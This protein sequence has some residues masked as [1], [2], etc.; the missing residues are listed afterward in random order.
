[1]KSLLDN[2]FLNKNK[3][4]FLIAGPCVIESKKMCLEHAAAL[5]E[6]CQRQGI[7]FIFKSSYD[8]A[9]RT[10]QK[11]FRGPGIKSGLS[12][13]KTVKRE[14]SVPICSDVHQLNEI[15]IAKDILDLIQIPALLCRQT[16]L[17]LAA[18]RTQKPINVKKG[19]FLSPNDM[20]N[21]VEKIINCG[22]KRIIITERGT[23][24]GYNNLVSDMR[25]IP[26]MKKFGFPIVFDATHSV[27]LPGAGKDKSHG[28]RQ[29]VETLALCAI[30]AGSNGLFLEVHKDPDSALCDGPNMIDFKKLED[31]LIKVKKIHAV[32]NE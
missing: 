28:E 16:D 11:S 17:I 25:S 3:P 6:I 12:I 20:F 32:I 1:M 18:A 7:F 27:Q 21:V 29:F 5:K 8:K 23:C 30:A 19:Q 22:N 15:K 14:I 24:F 4:L 10:S 31:L 13:L 26:I 2:I 9:N